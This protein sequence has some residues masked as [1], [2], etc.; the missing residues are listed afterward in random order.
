MGC[1]ALGP[2]MPLGKAEHEGS[3]TTRKASPQSSSLCRWLLRRR[4]ADCG[5]PDGTDVQKGSS[6]T[7]PSSSS[8]QTLPQAAWCNDA[9]ATDDF[10]YSSGTDSKDSSSPSPCQRPFNHEFTGSSVNSSSRATFNS[11]PAETVRINVTSLPSSSCTPVAGA[12]PVVGVGE[13]RILSAPLDSAND[14][15]DTSWWEPPSPRRL[16]SASRGSGSSSEPPL[17]LAGGLALSAQ[18]RNSEADRI[19]SPTS[20]VRRA[21]PLGG[22]AEPLWKP[23]SESA[24]VELQVALVRPLANEEWLQIETSKGDVSVPSK[25]GDP[26]RPPQ[27]SLSSPGDD[28]PDASSCSAVTDVDG[29]L[30]PRLRVRLRKGSDAADSVDGSIVTIRSGIS[31]EDPDTTTNGQT[32]SLPDFSTSDPGDPPFCACRS[33]ASATSEGL[34]DSAAALAALSHSC[35]AKEPKED[36]L[37][38]MLEAPF[39]GLE[40]ILED[41]DSDDEQAERS[42][43]PERLI[44]RSGSAMGFS[45]WRSGRGHSGPVGDPDP[46]TSSWLSPETLSQ[47]LSRAAPCAEVAPWNPQNTLMPCVENDS[48]DMARQCGH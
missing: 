47:E 44:V 46:S 15:E 14:V 41:D 30:L 36:S 8:S 43:R 42:E 38:F 11:P 2:S 22:L 23:R 37:T 45:S 19:G 9:L 28:L 20:R 34:P 48:L 33:E 27:R 21:S 18:W 12:Q 31:S 10:L 3:V 25:N 4:R 6:S 26:G 16:S 40:T 35:A 13:Y 17:T 29:S 1:G 5:G 39:A 7:C 32:D 24:A